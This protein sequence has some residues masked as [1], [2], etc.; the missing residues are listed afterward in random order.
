MDSAFRPLPKV[1]KREVVLAMPEQDP[2]SSPSFPSD[3]G[4]YPASKSFDFPPK[5]VLTT[6]SNSPSPDRA[7]RLTPTS[8]RPPRPPSDTLTRRRSLA[9][10][11][12][13]KPKSRFV[14][15]PQPA[16][17]YVVEGHD[18]TNTSTNVQSSPRPAAQSSPSRAGKT[19]VTPRT[20][21]G[22]GEDEEEEIIHEYIPTREKLRR[23]L[24]FWVVLEWVAFFSVTG[25]LAASL[26][27]HRLQQYVI[28]GLE[29]W[30][31]CLM[32][33]VIFCGRLVTAW[34]ITFL[35]FIIELNFL[36]K[37][38]VLY[39]VYGIKRSVQ[40]CL[41]A[42]LVILTWNL[43]FDRGVERSKRTRKF[44]DYFSRT[45]ATVMIG[46]VLWL[47]KALLVKLLASSFHVNTFFDRIQESIFHQY[48]LQ[49]LSGP[50]LMEMAEKIGSNRSAASTRST[51][52]VSFR[53]AKTGK[54]GEE[55]AFIDMAKLQ[56]VNQEKVSA[57]TMKKLVNTITTTGLWTLSHAV[58]E[59]VYED[60]REQKDEEITS[61]MEA[62]A[63]AYRIFKNVGKHG[64]K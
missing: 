56:K 13:S 15:Q 5:Q 1:E 24:K 49:T 44:L 12:Y 35:V 51:V 50:P 47:V 39:F 9:R 64:S 4:S 29:I 21:I 41:W 31:W 11:V 63:A 46:S 19:A 26:T 48:I 16:L 60:G 61:E 27:D 62:K 52:Q 25:L 8:N 28:W 3:N 55:Q 34:L 7:N 6:F 37:K 20:P 10:S 23:K 33:M 45:L 2:K 42:G 17:T 53:N 14:E 59:S 18:H 22:A 32:L 38:K 30:K 40:V 36:L 58:D 57:L 54:E 43:L